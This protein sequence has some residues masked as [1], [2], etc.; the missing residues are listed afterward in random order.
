MNN[1]GIVQGLVDLAALSESLAS[2]AV[3]NVAAKHALRSDLRF[4]F[5]AA[6]AIGGIMG[7]MEEEEGY[8]KD[9]SAAVNIR[10]AL[11]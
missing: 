1:G 3:T 5:I 10:S 8:D 7:P 4:R 2:L 11:R 9:Y 6:A